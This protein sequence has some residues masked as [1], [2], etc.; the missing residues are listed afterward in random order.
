MDVINI[1]KKSSPPVKTKNTKLT[2]EGFSDWFRKLNQR[3]IRE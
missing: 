1:D 3:G 2:R